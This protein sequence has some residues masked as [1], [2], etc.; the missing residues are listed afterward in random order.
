MKKLFATLGI[1]TLLAITGA[2]ANAQSDADL[3]SL[4]P[5]CAAD[6]AKCRRGLNAIFGLVI[7][8]DAKQEAIVL[9][10]GSDR[11]HPKSRSVEA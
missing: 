8:Y 10:S 5:Q 1:T 7:E 6:H 4:S 2:T 3:D 9:E 11:D